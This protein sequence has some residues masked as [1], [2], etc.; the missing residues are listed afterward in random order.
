M[1][2]AFFDSGRRNAGTPLEIA[3]TPVSAT[4]PDEK[5]FSRRKM[6][7]VPP[8]MFVALL[9]ERHRVDA[10]DVVEHEAAEQAVARRARRG[11]RCRCRSGP[12][13]CRP[14]SLMPRRLARLMQQ[15]QD[16][17]RARRGALRGPWNAGIDTIAATP[18]E[19]DTATVRM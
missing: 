4:A 7:S 16:R 19:I 15:D 10:A 13:R 14:D 5:P 17:G 8:K 9:L 3:S 2:A 18:A 12:R 1:V 11:S 6:P